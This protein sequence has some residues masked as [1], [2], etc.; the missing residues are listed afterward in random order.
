MVQGR[1]DRRGQPFLPV[2][3]AGLH[4]S[5][6]LQALV[7]TGFDGDLCV[8]IA[9]AM[10][11]GLELKGADYVELADGSIRRELIFRGTARIGDLPPKE[12]E[13]VLTESEQ[14]LIGAGMFEGL[15]LE[16]DYGA[17]TVLL[18]SSRRRGRR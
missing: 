9:V 12:A 7:D 17:G 5:L 6:T 10:P 3:L 4:R 1:F 14:P 18:R 13:I 16:I 11:L 8:P 15:R 2:E